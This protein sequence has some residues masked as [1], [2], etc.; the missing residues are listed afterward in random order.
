ML[1]WLIMCSKKNMSLK[2]HCSQEG[3]SANIAGGCPHGIMVKDCGFV[4]SNI[5]GT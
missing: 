2:G 5:T 4:V 3:I 1:Q